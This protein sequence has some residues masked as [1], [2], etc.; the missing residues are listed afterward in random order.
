MNHIGWNQVELHV[1]YVALCRR[2]SRTVDRYRT[3]L[4]RSAAY[5]TETSLSLVILHIYAAYTLQRVP[6]IRVGELA[7]LVGR[8]HVSYVDVVFLG[9]Y[10]SMLPGENARDHHFVQLL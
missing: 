4:R 5:L 10:R 6:D 9:I 3:E 8:Y 1:A 2:Q 7:D